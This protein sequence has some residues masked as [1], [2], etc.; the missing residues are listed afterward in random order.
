VH[1]TLTPPTPARRSL[2]DWL[3]DRRI[4][5]IANERFRRWAARFPFTR[6]MARRE[7]RAL[8]DLAAG[9]VYAQVLGACVQLGV[10]ETLRAGPMALAELAARLQLP[11]ESAQR[12]VTA[13]VGLR[14]LARRSDG[15]VALGSLGAA[16]IDNPGVSAM[17]A[18]HGHL[19][20]DL[21]DPVALLRGGSAGHL[22]GYWPYAGAAAPGALDAEAVGTYSAL[23]AAS[24]PMVAAEVLDA[25]DFTRHRCLL[26]VGGGEGAFLQAVAAQAPALQLRLFDLP[27]VAERAT[28][29]FAK[30][31]LAARAAAT[32]GDFRADALPQGAD[33]ISLVRVAHDHD[34]ATVLALLRACRQALPKGATLLLAEPMAET[35]GAETVGA[36]FAFYLLAMGQ[37]AASRMGRPRSAAELQAML[38]AT[39]FARARLCATATPL[40]T[41]VMVADAE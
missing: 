15:A 25:Y 5:L 36:Y 24:Q 30:A 31:G 14:L 3:D 12:L 9:F 8:F 33:I 19:Y 34:D 38:A 4:A 28:A 18:H 27:A 10:F 35:E 29:R 2:R 22:A 40:V 16:M 26:D 7:A 1:G 6:P 20:A 32:G 39:G 21:A 23:M 13:A 41:R 17:V 37:G 11:P